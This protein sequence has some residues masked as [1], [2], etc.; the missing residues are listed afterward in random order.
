MAMT[1]EDYENKPVDFD[2]NVDD[3]DESNLWYGRKNYMDHNL[4]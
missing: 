2:D 3:D 4:A 1:R